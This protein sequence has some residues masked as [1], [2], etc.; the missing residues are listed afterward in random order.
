MNKGRCRS[1]G[2]VGSSLSYDLSA[3]CIHVKGEKDTT[4]TLVHYA[5]KDLQRFKEDY[6]FLAVVRAQN[7]RNIHTERYCI[8]EHCG[9]NLLLLYLYPVYDLSNHC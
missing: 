9:I 7:K 4:T 6:T 2:V 8:L 1:L 3:V 5:Q